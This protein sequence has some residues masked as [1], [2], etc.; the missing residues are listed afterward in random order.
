MEKVDTLV[1]ANGSV[2]P[3]PAAVRASVRDWRRKRAAS[4]DVQ[5]VEAEGSARLCAVRGGEEG[6]DGVLAV[7][8]CLH[9]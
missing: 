3:A 8:L 6:F 2:S 4:S 9:C 5:G 1:S 7:R